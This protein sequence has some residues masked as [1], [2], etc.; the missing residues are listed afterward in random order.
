MAGTTPEYAKLVL[1]RL[2]KAH[3]VTEIERG[4]FTVHADALLV[5]SRIAWPSYISLWSALRYHD[6][7]EQIP[8]AVWVVSTR[9]RKRTRLTFAD[10]P[11]MFVHTKHRYLF[12]YDKVEYRGFEIFVADPEKSVIDCLLFRRVSVSETFDVLKAN[13]KT[14]RVGRLVEY[15]IRTD[16]GALIKRLGHMLD[17]LGRDPYEK[18]KKHVYAAPVVLEYG[19]P[20]KG[21]LNAKWGII[22]NV[23]L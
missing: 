9:K 6:L 11:I 19:M 16:N 17:R 21:K 22:E 14:L 12:G 7:T 5:A 13:I 3:Q 1:Q 4:T 8:H 23:M 15:A 2:K 18:L 10:I 20:R